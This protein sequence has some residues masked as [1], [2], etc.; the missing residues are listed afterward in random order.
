[1]KPLIFNLAMSVGCGVPETKTAGETK[2]EKKA[3][4]SLQIPS[5]SEFFS[6]RI[7]NCVS[8]TSSFGKKIFHS[9]R[10]NAES[11]NYT[12]AKSD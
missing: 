2:N 9:G 12:P 3:G 7:E 6:V 4:N 1:M 10:Q 11:V 5:R 8:L